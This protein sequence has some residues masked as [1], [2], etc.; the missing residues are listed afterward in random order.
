LVNIPLEDDDE[1]ESQENLAV[2]DVPLEVGLKNP[3]VID[4]E[5]DM[6][7]EVEES[8]SQIAQIPEVSQDHSTG[9]SHSVLIKGQAVSKSRALAQFS[10]YRKTASSTD[11]LKHVQQ[12]GQYSESTLNPDPS[13]V[14]ATI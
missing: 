7:V 3:R 12:Q 8:I 2:P 14:S 13:T 11:R 6:Q 10:K 4:L 9:F 1:D 5:A